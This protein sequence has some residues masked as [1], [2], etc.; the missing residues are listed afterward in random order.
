MP[1][2]APTYDIAKTYDENFAAGPVYAGP[3]PAFA[4]PK[5][6]F[7]FLGHELAS[8]IGVPAGP[9]LNSAYTALYAR[10]GWDVPVY[11]TVRSVERACHPAPNCLFVP[12][13]TLDERDALSTRA[14]IPEPDALTALTITNSFGMP[15]K[16]PASWQADVRAAEAAMGPGQLLIVSVVGTP[17]AEGR[18]LAEDFAHTAMLAKAAGARVI[19]A[20]FSC[21]NVVSCEGALYSDP[22]TSAAVTRAIK[23]AIGDTPLLIKIG[24]LDDG[25]LDAVVRANLPFIDGIAAINTVPLNV[26]DAQG[27]QALPGEGRLKSGVCG[28]AIGAVATRMTERLLR[29]RDR[30]KAGYAVV[31]VGGVMSGDDIDARLAMGAD[32]VMSATAAMWDPLIAARWKT[33]NA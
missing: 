24:S 21:P 9:L 19:E 20:N 32:L 13:D 5:R 6:T 16:A 2:P 8:P 7:S 3:I 29:T 17:G 10:L 4:P 33:R 27:R 14:A 18:G 30:L 25:Q 26:V 1:L 22:V 23:E 12:A 28:A 15:S 31:S 11:K